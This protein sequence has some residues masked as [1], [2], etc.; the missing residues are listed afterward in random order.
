M[1][2]PQ[3]KPDSAGQSKEIAWKAGVVLKDPSISASHERI[4]TDF[5]G[6]LEPIL[7]LEEDVR[8]HR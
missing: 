7:A 2:P 5:V 1:W 8:K 6:R 4:L 3:S